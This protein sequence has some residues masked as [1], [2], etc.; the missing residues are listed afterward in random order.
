MLFTSC[1]SDNEKDNI[2]ID[3]NNEWL[4]DNII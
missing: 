4:D 3:K 1:S 2:Y